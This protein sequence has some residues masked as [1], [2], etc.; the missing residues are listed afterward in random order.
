MRNEALAQNIGLDGYEGGI[1]LDEMSIQEDLELRKKGTSFDL[2]GFNAGLDETHYMKTLSAGKESLQMA[3]HVL[4]L[5]FLGHTGFRFPFAHYHTTQV[6]PAELLLIFWQA[7]KMLG[8][9]GFTVTYV[10]LDGAQCNRDF[11]KMLIEGKTP[12]TMFYMSIPNVFFDPTKPNIHIIM[13]Y[14]HVIKKN[15]KQYIKK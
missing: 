3:S 14:S 8:V 6:T 4:Q 7:V 11:M 13:D 10:S 9:F 15:S 2:I 1:M 12:E 5:L